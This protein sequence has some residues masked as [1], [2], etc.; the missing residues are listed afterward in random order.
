MRNGRGMNLQQPSPP[1]KAGIERETDHSRMY[2]AMSMGQFKPLLQMSADHRR[3]QSTDT[4]LALISDTLPY[5]VLKIVV[6]TIC[7]SYVTECLVLRDT[8]T[9]LVSH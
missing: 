3:S 5:T 1:K 9:E 8:D 4:S 7:V 2:F 6:F